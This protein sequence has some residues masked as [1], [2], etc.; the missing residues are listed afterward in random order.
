MRQGEVMRQPRE[1]QAKEEVRG[2]EVTLVG[3]KSEEKANPKGGENCIRG[4][5]K[6][7]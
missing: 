4:T 5:G 1:G 6:N 7:R 3:W 2:R